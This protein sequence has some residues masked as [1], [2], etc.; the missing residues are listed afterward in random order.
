M[1]VSEVEVHLFMFSASHCSCSECFPK[2]PPRTSV[3]RAGFIHT[4]S[5]DTKGSVGLR[6]VLVSPSEPFV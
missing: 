5:A 3:M 6:M 2:M 1:H 4:V